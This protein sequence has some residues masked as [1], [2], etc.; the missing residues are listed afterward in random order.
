MLQVRDAESLAQLVRG[1]PIREVV[2]KPRDAEAA[3]AVMT[4]QVVA[5]EPID[6]STDANLHPCLEHGSPL[7]V[8]QTAPVFAHAADLVGIVDNWLAVRAFLEQLDRIGDGPGPQLALVPQVAVELEEPAR[9]LGTVRV[10][11][12]E[13]DVEVADDLRTPVMKL[14]VEVLEPSAALRQ[15]AD[16][17]MGGI[18]IAKRGVCQAPEVGAVKPNLHHLGLGVLDERQIPRIG[19]LVPMRDHAGEF[20]PGP[21]GLGDP[22]RRGPEDQDDGDGHRL[23]EDG[24]A[25]QGF[26]HAE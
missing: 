11:D 13:L 19:V 21:L 26:P 2:A 5:N 18:T 4:I 24:W 22:F 10:A 25:H 20:H 23:E 6:A 12:E 7:G 3:E 8:V 17:K 1:E 16:R 14:C 15:A 9:A